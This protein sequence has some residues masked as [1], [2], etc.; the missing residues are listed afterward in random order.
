[1]QPRASPPEF[2]SYMSSSPR[3]FCMNTVYIEVVT[4]NLQ[5]CRKC[6]FPLA[7]SHSSFASLI[8]LKPFRRCRWS[9]WIAR[10]LA[11]QRAQQAA[12]DDRHVIYIFDL[13]DVWS[14]LC[15]SHDQLYRSRFSQP[16]THSNHGS[17]L[18]T[19]V[20]VFK[21]HDGEENKS[22]WKEVIKQVQNAY[23]R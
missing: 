13:R 9:S 23:T 5:L 16:N 7:S 15:R 10:F 8:E 17:S 19:N 18:N 11:I 12:Q 3:L 2:Q 21:R 4:C 1:M 22:F 14:E 6:C 20:C